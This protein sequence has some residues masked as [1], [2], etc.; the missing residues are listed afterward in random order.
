MD[1]FDRLPV[2]FGLV[3]YGV[4]PDHQGTKS[5]SRVLGRVLGKANVRFLGNVEVGLDV[6][7]D[8][9]RHAYDSVVLAVGVGVDRRLGIEGEDLTG[10]VGSWDFIA[11]INGRPGHG[12]PP[13]NLIGIRDVVVIGLGNVAIDVARLLLNTEAQF[14][15]SDLDQEVSNTL[16]SM[17]IQRVTIVGRGNL[18]ESRFGQ[19]ELRKLVA[20]PDLA[21]VVTPALTGEDLGK[22][23]DVLGA[24]TSAA[25]R[26]L[27][28]HFGAAPVAIE[29][30]GRISALR[31]RTSDG[32]EQHL[33]AD[34][35]V[36]CVGYEAVPF[37]ELPQ[38]GGRFVH[39]GHRIDAGLY[40]V[41]WAATGPQGTIAASR[42]VAYIVADRML[43]ETSA[44]GRL[45]STPDCAIDFDGWRQIDA[46]ETASPPEGRC[47]SKTLTIDAMLKLARYGRQPMA[48]TSRA[49]AITDLPERFNAATDLI[50]H[51][52]SAGRGSKIAVHDYNGATTYAE[53]AVRINRMASALRQVGIQQE[54]RI[55]L[56]LL[57]T[58]DFPTA[59]LGAIKAGIVPIPLNTLITAD[60]YRWILGNSRAVAVIVSDEI[61]DVWK[62]IASEFPRVRFISS[63]GS[64]PWDHLADLLRT[65]DSACEAAETY[66][67]D[68]AFWLY[69][70][71][72]TGRPKGAMHAHSSMRLTAN[73][74]AKGV[75]GY[76][77]HD[78]CLSVAKQFFAYGLGNGLSFPFSVGATVV[79]HRDR[80]TPEAISVLL[81]K[82][83]VT[84]LNGVPTFFADWLS[85]GLAPQGPDVPDL[86]MATSAGECLPAHL[87]EAFR[88]RY[89][90]DILDG[91]GS[92]EM[93]HV[94]LSQRPGSVRYGF[95]GRPVPGY[96]LRIIGDDDRLCAPGELGELQ[97]KGP[98]SAIGYWSN[99]IKSLETFQ[100]EWTRSGDKYVCDGDGWYSFGGRGD[101]MLKVGGI[102]VSPSEVEEALSCHELVL[103]AA[104]VGCADADGLIKPRAYVVLAAGVIATAQI[105]VALKAHVKTRLAPYKYPRWIDFVEALPKTAT[106]K[107]QRFRLRERA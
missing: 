15:R 3:R 47:R 40:V 79:L 34:L 70:S 53:L 6:S 60:D 59:F 50:D 24:C 45:G 37:C 29:G 66:R 46:A 11:W 10:V 83:R 80:A 103:E 14:E 107:I 52:L 88:K 26:T 63:G 1:V 61:S 20:L 54:Q 72:S 58:I 76:H 36:T 25:K 16:L 31:V 41:G 22:T 28:F 12:S 9:L 62:T 89:G 39:E 44:T 105:E 71:G 33:P 100:G 38:A 77:E 82:H 68:T 102:Y 69:T 67:D 48:S 91:L 96:D 85:S 86:R 94:Y 7:L 95:T 42:T 90:A 73:L 56:C 8:T 75:V 5:V 78:T 74:F 101:D 51:N 49:R 27:S 55:L 30:K 87:G 104:V 4:A 57:D 99:R 98:T 106:G 84:I 32:V 93:L 35:L 64:G 21:T 2:P 97:V 43:S 17:N 19:G 81:K 92:T 13:A 18:S 65:A 23:A